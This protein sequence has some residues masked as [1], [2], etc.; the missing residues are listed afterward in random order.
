VR[1]ERVAYGNT[2][3]CGWKTQG[4]FQYWHC[5]SAD[6]VEDLPTMKA[7]RRIDPS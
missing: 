7:R 6:R 3:R 4:N 1:I 5:G 2:Q